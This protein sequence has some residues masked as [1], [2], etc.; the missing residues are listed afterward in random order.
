MN[1]P[2]PIQEIVDRM[3]AKLPAPGTD[4]HVPDDLNAERVAQVANRLEDVPPKFADATAVGFA[5]D[6]RA[7]VTHFL[8]EPDVR[9]ILFSGPTGVGKTHL[10]WAIYRGLAD[11]LG[12]RMRIVNVT[13]VLESMKPGGDD[14]PQEQLTRLLSVP[15]L[16]LDDL[17]L[18]TA[19]DWEKKVL[20]QL[21]NGRY[22][23]MLPM[24]ITTNRKPDALAEFIGERVASRLKEDCIELLI[25]GRDRRYE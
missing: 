4:L 23:A 19:S 9:G 2:T 14:S 17:A 21:V 22:E 12:P 6:V 25:T 13:D 1:D 16:G 20:Y 7:V 15:V 3:R 24:V 10:L 8:N 18:A 5:P 11:R